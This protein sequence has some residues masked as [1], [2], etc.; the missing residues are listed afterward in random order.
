MCVCVGGGGGGGVPHKGNQGPTVDRYHSFS[1]SLNQ[2]LGYPQKQ[3]MVQTVTKETRFGVLRALSFSGF[4]GDMMAS[5][6]CIH[7]LML[8]K[9]KR[10]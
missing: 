10:Q 9:S 5:A 3:V 1:C 8:C 2:A 6:L 4:G 7:C